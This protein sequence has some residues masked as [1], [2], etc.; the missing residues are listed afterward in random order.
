[1]NIND[2]MDQLQSRETAI[3]DEVNFFNKNV[4]WWMGE[5]NRIQQRFRELEKNHF[6]DAS[7]NE[8]DELTAAMNYLAAKATTERKTALKIYQKCNKFN[9]EKELFFIQ[10]DFRNMKSRREKQKK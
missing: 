10:E 5:I 9:L 3:Q 1:M 7:D 4:E 8:I 2:K 6:S